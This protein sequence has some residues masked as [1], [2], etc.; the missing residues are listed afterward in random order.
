MHH[1]GDATAHRSLRP[2]VCLRDIQ[3]SGPPAAPGLGPE[4]HIALSAELDSPFRPRDWP[5]PDVLSVAEC[6]CAWRDHL[7]AL[8]TAQ[9]HILQTVARANTAL[10]CCPWVQGKVAATTQPLSPASLAC[11]VGLTVTKPNISPKAIPVLARLNH[12][13]CS[14]RST[15]LTRLALPLGLQELLT[16]NAS[17]G[18]R[19]PRMRMSS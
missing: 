18:H 17:F 5:E 15:N 7:S 2:E 16:C 12:V 19:R 10:R 1:Y 6:V 14:S 3:R 8:A 9:R 13:A 11:C 4:A